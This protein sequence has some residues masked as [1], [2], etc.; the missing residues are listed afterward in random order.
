MDIKNLLY[1]S[2]GRTKTESVWNVPLS[3]WMMDF[4]AGL[5]KISWQDEAAVTT[6]DASIYDTLCSWECRATHCRLPWNG[7]T[8]LRTP[9]A[10]SYDA[11]MVCSS[12][13]LPY[14]AAICMLKAKLTGH[15]L[16][17]FLFVMRNHRVECLCVNVVTSCIYGW[18]RIQWPWK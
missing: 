4:M 18:I 6:D 1:E 8:P 17:Y 14:L 11:L 9:I 2:E 12:D 16:Q 15:M 5:S 7:R 3:A 13:S 10:A